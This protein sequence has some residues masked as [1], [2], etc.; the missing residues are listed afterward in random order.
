MPK[1][2][3]HLKLKILKS[4]DPKIE[5]RYENIFIIEPLYHKDLSP[6]DTSSNNGKLS[7]LN[8]TVGV[9]EYFVEGDRTVKGTI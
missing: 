3:S 7:F 2:K 5:T 1:T 6:S 8:N 9:F 4:P